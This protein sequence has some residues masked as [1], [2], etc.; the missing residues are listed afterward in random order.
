MKKTEY[1][2]R[3]DDQII[4]HENHMLGV[5]TQQIKKYIPLFEERGCSLRVGLMW[6]S[7]PRNTTV[8]Q[9][10]SFRNGYQCYIYCVVQKDDRDVH[11]H[12]IDGEADYYSLST[13]WLVSSIYREFY[14]L[15][16]SLCVSID[17]VDA[18]LNSFLTQLKH[19]EERQS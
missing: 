9:R 14:K 16:V 8:F 2:N 18:D 4:A 10:E 11:I 12:S 19:I 7:L 1:S 5:Y 3:I 13:A 17:D 6:K 15:T